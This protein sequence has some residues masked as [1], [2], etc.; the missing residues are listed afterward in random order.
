MPQAHSSITF[1]CMAYL[2]HH[3]ITLI[4]PDYDHESKRVEVGKGVHGLCRYAQEH[5]LEHL[6]AY[7]STREGS[8]DDHKERIL[9][10]LDN[11]ANA[12]SRFDDNAPLGKASRSLDVRLDLL[13]GRDPSY[14]FAT[15]VIISQLAGRIAP[16][17]DDDHG[18]V[19]L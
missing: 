18:I 16:A 3:G 8:H 14:T 13:K 12:L 19:K 5:W 10:A 4:E 2:L 6:L 17:K 1:I 11:L 15:R 9:L 7:L